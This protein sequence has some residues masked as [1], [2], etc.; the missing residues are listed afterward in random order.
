[1]KMIISRSFKIY[2]NLISPFLGMNCRFEPSCSRYSETAFE[3]YGFF[4]G[5][6]LT[7]KRILKCSPLH[8]GGWDP[9]E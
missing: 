3:K 9:L 4:K 2:R 5:L 7:I 6:F 8:S 1:M